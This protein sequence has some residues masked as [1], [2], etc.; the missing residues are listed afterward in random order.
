M[1]STDCLLEHLIA[2]T[3]LGLRITLRLTTAAVGAGVEQQ[4]R[5]DD[6]GHQARR[7]LFGGHARAQVAAHAAGVSN[8][9]KTAMA[10]GSVVD[11]T[12]YLLGM[13]KVTRAHAPRQVNTVLEGMKERLVICPGPLGA[14][15]RSSRFPQ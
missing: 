1:D 2:D 14:F 12:E 11:T 8:Y 15:K 5:A 3:L 4:P 13:I 6:E 10:C 9:T 7:H